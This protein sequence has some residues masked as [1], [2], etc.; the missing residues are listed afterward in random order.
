MKVQHIKTNINEAVNKKIKQDEDS[1]FEGYS[2]VTYGRE[3]TTVDI[4][5]PLFDID[6]D[7]IVVKWSGKLE[8]HN[9]GVYAFNVDVKSI[10]ASSEDQAPLNFNGFDFDIEKI[11]NPEVQEIQIFIQSL[12]IATEEKKIYVKFTI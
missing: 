8:M 5:S 2:F 10:T 11:K 3:I 9:D 12:F 6:S 4:D 1:F 7:S